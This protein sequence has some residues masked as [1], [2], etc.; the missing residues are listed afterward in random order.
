MNRR[1]YYADTGVLSRKLMEWV[2]RETSTGLKPAFAGSFGGAS[3][4]ILF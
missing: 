2:R 4:R 1:E 3:E